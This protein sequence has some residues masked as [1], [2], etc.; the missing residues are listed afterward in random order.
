MITLEE[1]SPSWMA[2][3]PALL[4]ISS[5]LPPKEDGLQPGPSPVAPEPLVRMARA[6][7][8]LQPFTLETY[9]E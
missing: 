3:L 2:A 7:W 1:G 9:A 8:T 4:L 6:S 5:S